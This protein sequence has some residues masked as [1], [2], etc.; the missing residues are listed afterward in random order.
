MLGAGEWP[1]HVTMSGLPSRVAPAASEHEAVSSAALADN[2]DEERRS[3]AVLAPLSFKRLFLVQATVSLLGSSTLLAAPECD[4]YDTITSLEVFARDLK[5]NFTEDKM[6]SETLIVEL[7]T[8]GPCHARGPW[9][10]APISF[11]GSH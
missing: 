1:K 2:L 5:V 9:Q 10:Q 4:C 7:K 6:S 8:R 11:C 3:H